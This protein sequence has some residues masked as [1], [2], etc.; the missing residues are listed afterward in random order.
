MP[1]NPVVLEFSAAPEH[2]QQPG[3]SHHVALPHPRRG[4]VSR[5]RG[6]PPTAFAQ[7]APAA[8]PVDVV[9]EV[10][11]GISSVA[12]SD[13]R[14]DWHQR[15]IRRAFAPRLATAGGDSP[16]GLVRSPREYPLG[17]ACCLFRPAAPPTLDRLRP[18]G[19]SWSATPTSC[20]LLRFKKRQDR[21]RD[22]RGE[23][24][25]PPTRAKSIAPISR[26]EH[27]SL[28]WDVLRGERSR[29]G[30]RGQGRASEPWPRLVSG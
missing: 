30:S 3:L 13:S 27:R 14:T 6:S 7:G 21:L 19:G 4:A 1:G 18:A 26:E 12:V 17:S 24:P 20:S 29:A 5:P 2:R 11:L 16:R 22:R 15:G 25:H 23:R 8:T 10:R 28:T 9:L